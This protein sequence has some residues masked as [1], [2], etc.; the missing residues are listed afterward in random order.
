MAGAARPAAGSGP[1]SCT[2]TPSRPPWRASSPRPCA[3]EHVGV[4]RRAPSRRDPHRRPRHQRHQGGRVGRRGS[5][6]PSA[7]ARCECTMPRATGPSRI[8][9][10][11]GP[12][13]SSA[14]ASARSA[15]G[16]AAGGRV[17]MPSRRSA[18]RRRARPSCRWPPMPAPLGPALLWSD[19]RAGAEAVA[20]AESFGD[21]GA[22]RR[23]CVDGARARARRRVG[24]GQGGMA[25][26]SR[27]AADRDG[28]LAA[29]PP[30]DLAGVA[31][32][33]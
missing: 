4:G 18:S 13:W 1:R 11:G 7:G 26:A 32:H 21:G 22:R 20:L 31:P 5:G 15:L 12:R 10:R 30:R 9:R 17:R 19:R 2:R 3:T 23:A 6:W 14:C 29:R 16:A 27:A 25:G 33:G 8:P 24:G 28:A